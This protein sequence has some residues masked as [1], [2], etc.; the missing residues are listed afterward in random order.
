MNYDEDAPF[1]VPT[2]REMQRSIPGVEGL[3]R[4]VASVLATQVAAGGTILVV[5]A[6][7]GREIE[8]LA[9]TGLHALGVDPSAEMLALAR[10]QSEALGSA[11]RVE[12]IQGTV[13]DL[14]DTLRADGATSLLVMHFLPDDEAPGG[15]AAY[16]R[17]IRQRL[18]PGA[19]LLHA[20]V[21]FADRAA[22]ERLVPVFLRHAVL[23]GLA[24][25]KAAIAPPVIEG[26]PVV[27][28][29]RA[30]A[31]L[32]AAGFASPMLVFQALWYRLWWATAM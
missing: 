25:E 16:L 17:A 29:A 2:Y 15:K 14:R 26:L 24:P 32:A 9:P 3:Y 10:A 5:G 12:L 8:L 7:G 22:F 11:G 31:L 21:S 28:E 1:P 27:S 23:A 30:E 4:V 13:T 18:R 19:P 6:G 20:D